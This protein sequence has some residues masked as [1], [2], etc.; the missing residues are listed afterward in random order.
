MLSVA[1]WKRRACSWVKSSSAGV[2]GS[3]EVRHDQHGPHFL[4]RTQIVG[5]LRRFIHAEPQPGHAGV[6]FDGNRQRLRPSRQMA[7][8][9]D[10]LKGFPGYGPAA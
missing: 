2:S 1:S 6:E 9:K 4:E 7:L 3:G 8:R 5:Q 10:P